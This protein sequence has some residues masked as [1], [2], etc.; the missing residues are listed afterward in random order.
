M[1]T[2]LAS[3]GAV[4]R[5]IGRFGLR[6]QK[7][8]GQNFLISPA[9]VAQIVAA[10]DL[11]PGAPVLEIGPGIGTL[12]QGLAKTGAAVTAVELDPALPAILAET[13]APYPNVRIVSGDI[14]QTDIPGLMGNEPF[15]VA[16]NLPYYI[17]TPIL[18]H[19]LEAGLPLRRLVLMMQK[20]V[21]ERLTATPGTKAYGAVTVAVQYYTEAEILFEVPPESF[22]PPPNVISAV[23]LFRP[24]AVPPVSV[25]DERML[26][27]I[28]RL[29]FAQRRKTFRNNLRAAGWDPEACDRLLAAAGIDGARRGETF[30][31]EE[32]ARLADAA[33]ALQE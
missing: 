25:R 8:W 3:K 1:E 18:L 6:L 7:K 15:T 14:L 32:F 19:L 30:S 24:R 2:N 27:R 28:V 31:L 5:I 17:T 10:A 29:A 4:R 21:A 26:F 33:A 22:L 20:E 13:L 9:T 11:T 16:A 12:T 23:A